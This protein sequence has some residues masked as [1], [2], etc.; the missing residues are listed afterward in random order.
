MADPPDLSQPI[1]DAA[2]AGIQSHAVDGQ[3]TVAKPISELI[4]ADKY[5][6]SRAALAKGRRG[7]K[8]AKLVPPGAG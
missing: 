1:Q 5:M 6:A 7:F 3:M 8:L 4:A 2:T